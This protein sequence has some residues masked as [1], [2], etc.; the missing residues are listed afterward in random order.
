MAIN[1]YFVFKNKN[2]YVV[3]PISQDRVV[4]NISGASFYL[5]HFCNLGRYLHT[6]F[7]KKEEKK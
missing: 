6:M 3:V 2:S 5:T 1:G 7:D 4:T